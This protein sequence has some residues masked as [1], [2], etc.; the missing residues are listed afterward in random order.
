MATMNGTIKRLTDKGFGFIA[1]NDGTDVLLSSISL[2]R[3]TLRRIARRPVG[4]VRA[5]AGPERPAC[6]KRPRQLVAE[7]CQARRPREG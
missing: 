3:H 2:H 4:H 1:A 5:R 6:R 7:S